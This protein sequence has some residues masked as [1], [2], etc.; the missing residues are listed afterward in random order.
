MRR[1]SPTY[2]YTRLH[3]VRRDLCLTSMEA[4]Y[5]SGLA[6]S[7]DKNHNGELFGLTLAWNSF[8]F[9]TLTGFLCFPVISFTRILHASCCHSRQNTAASRIRR[10]ISFG[11][12]NNNNS[13][14]YNYN[15]QKNCHTRNITHH[16]ESDTSW[17]LKPEWWGSP[18]A[19]EKKCQGRKKTCDKK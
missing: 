15:L 14:Y 16:K 1:L 7:T 13:Y 18:L 12:N 9:S 4:A 8:C 17:D 10:A 5:C 11:P 3:T 2:L 6:C 19:Q